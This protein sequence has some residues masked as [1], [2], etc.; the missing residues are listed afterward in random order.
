MVNDKLLY[1]EYPDIEKGTLVFVLPWRDALVSGCARDALSRFIRDDALLFPGGVARTLSV[2]FRTS[3]SFF[4]NRQGLTA[5]EL[6]ELSC[7]GGSREG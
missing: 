4:P 2:V 6:F 5:Q 7:S 1:P 3:D